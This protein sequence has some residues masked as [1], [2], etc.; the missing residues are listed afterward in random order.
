MQAIRLPWTLNNEEN[1]KK[2]HWLAGKT[3]F[4][5]GLLIVA[6]ALLAPENILI[7]VFVVIAL[8]TTIIPAVYSYRLH[9]Q[10]KISGKS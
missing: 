5:G 9:R 6:A 4:A 8:V 1:W 2:T 3:W 10:Q 7:F